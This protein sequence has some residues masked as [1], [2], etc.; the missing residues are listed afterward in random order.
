MSKAD[1][2]AQAAASSQ[3]SGAAQSS[4]VQNVATEPL[5]SPSATLKAFAEADTTPSFSSRHGYQPRV[6]SATDSD[7]E[8]DSDR[9]TRVHMSV[10]GAVEYILQATKGRSVLDDKPNLGNEGDNSSR[11]RARSVQAQPRFSI[12]SGSG[13]NDIDAKNSDD[14]Q[15]NYRNRMAAQATQESEIVRAR[16]K[17]AVKL[18][19]ETRRKDIAKI[20]I[21]IF[22]LNKEHIST[23]LEAKRMIVS[24]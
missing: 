13:N 17:A 15:H 9:D 7:Y 4:T 10:K 11:P 8:A 19:E 16:W 6:E 21:G 22:A 23:C 3:T 1:A 2:I 5:A 24:S 12:S 20:R 18:A 14:D